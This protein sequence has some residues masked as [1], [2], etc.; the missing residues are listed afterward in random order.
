MKKIKIFLDTS[1]PS[2]LFADDSTD[3]KNV[4]IQFWDLLKI[5]VF[6]VYVSDVL[7]IEINRAQKPLRENLIQSIRDISPV[8]IHVDHEIIQLSNHYVTEQV[9]PA[10]FRDDA[11]HLASAT[12]TNC[13]AVVSWNFK[14]FVNLKIIRGIN[15]VNRMLG[16]K[17]IEILTPQSWIEDNRYE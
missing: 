2:F 16:Y 4:T 11:L 12:I 15:G 3:K 1:I 13:D 9:V 17:E 8:T 6:D 7:F 10:K 5:G 14:H